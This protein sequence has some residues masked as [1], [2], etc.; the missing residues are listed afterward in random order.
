MQREPRTATTRNPKSSRVVTTSRK[1][2]ACSSK[3][4]PTRSSTLLE[5]SQTGQAQFF[6]CYTLKCAESKRNPPEFRARSGSYLV[7]G[8]HIVLSREENPGQPVRT[9]SGARIAGSFYTEVI[10]HGIGAVSTRGPG[11]PPDYKL[12]EGSGEQ[13]A[14]GIGA[15]ADEQ[16]P[17]RR[18]CTTE[19]H[20]LG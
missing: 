18:K 8:G 5:S 2:E 3:P 15:W 14:K 1:R 12:L 19:A 17:I 4:A 9:R 11:E 6:N 20:F 13:S 16:L 10:L 7:G